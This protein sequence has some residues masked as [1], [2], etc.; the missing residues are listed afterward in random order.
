MSLPSPALFHRWFSRDL[1]FPLSFI[2]PPPWAESILVQVISLVPLPRSSYSPKSSA[3]PHPPQT[4]SLS[5]YLPISN[6]RV[7]LISTEGIWVQF[8]VLMQ[9]A[10][11]RRPS[12]VFHVRR[13]SDDLR[14][15]YFNSAPGGYYGPGMF[16]SSYPW[17]TPSRPLSSVSRSFL[18]CSCHNHILTMLT[19]Y[20]YLCQLNCARCQQWHHP[21]CALSGRPS[22]WFNR[23]WC[24]I[25]QWCRPIEDILLVCLVVMDHVVLVVI[26]SVGEY[27][28][29]QLFFF[30]LFLFWS[31]HR[32]GRHWEYAVDDFPPFMTISLPPIIR[33]P[34]KTSHYF[35][36]PR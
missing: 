30:T 23:R 33:L 16:H 13:S 4:F 36:R 21:K 9:Y 24:I 12:N 20:S 11:V 26:L 10:S 27:I 14:S 29:F 7:R 19:N 18:P 34:D 6:S 3:L 2:S 15:P 31:R 5:V 32:G 8:S 1:F 28:Y 35:P 22:R 25:H 17:L